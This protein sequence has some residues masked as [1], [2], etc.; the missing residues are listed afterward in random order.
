MSLSYWLFNHI[1][2]LI[3]GQDMGIL[4]IEQSYSFN[5]THNLTRM[6]SEC[7]TTFQ[8]SGYIQKEISLYDLLWTPISNGFTKNN[9]IYQN[10]LLKLYQ[11]LKNNPD[12]YTKYELA[13]DKGTHTEFVNFVKNVIDICIEH[14][15]WYINTSR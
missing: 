1:P 8:E 2:Y 7:K 6:A 9:R 13:K 3:D 11:E 14:D 4:S 15:N 5:I 10:T 12:K